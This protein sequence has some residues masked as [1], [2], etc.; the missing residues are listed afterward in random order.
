MLT[1]RAERLKNTPGERNDFVKSVHLLIVFIVGLVW[2]AHSVDNLM[3][4]SAQFPAEDDLTPDKIHENNLYWIK[5]T[6]ELPARPGICLISCLFYTVRSAPGCDT[7]IT[8]YKTHS[9]INSRYIIMVRSN[10]IYHEIRRPNQGQILNYAFKISYLGWMVKEE[11]SQ[12]GKQFQVWVN[13][14]TTMG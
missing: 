12:Y 14:S 5:H 1:L 7:Q 4:Y 6:R 2:G 9:Y 8:L 13:N 10:K 11:E 3:C